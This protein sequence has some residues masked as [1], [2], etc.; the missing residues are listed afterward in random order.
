MVLYYCDT[1]STRL[2]QTQLDDGAFAQITP[3]TLRCM[4]C[5][6]AAA[7][8]AAAPVAASARSTVVIK[9]SKSDRS[10]SRMTPAQAPQHA[11]VRAEAPSKFPLIPVLGGVVLMLAVLVGFLLTRKPNTTAASANE[12]PATAAIQVPKNSDPTPP[13]LQQN[14]KPADAADPKSTGAK[15]LATTTP[16]TPRT[17]P[18]DVN[19]VK[20]GTDTVAPEKTVPAVPD[21]APVPGEWTW[22][23]DSVPAGVEIK[24]SWSWVSSPV[25]SGKLAHTQGDYRNLGEMLQHYFEKGAGPNVEPRDVFFAYVFMDSKNPPLEIMLQ[26]QIAGNWDHRAFWGE[27]R[28][29]FGTPN[30]P[31]RE[32]MGPLPKAGEWVRLEVPVARVGVSQGALSGL[33]FVQWGGTVFWD[34]AGIVKASGEAGPTNML[35]ALT[36]SAT[37]AQG[38]N[39]LT[40]LA[41]PAAQTGLQKLFLKDFQGGGDFNN[42]AGGDVRPSKAI[43]GKPNEKQTL[44]GAF[45]LPA[46]NYGAAT[47]V[48]T[49]HRHG[50]QCLIIFQLNGKEIFNGRDPAPRP[51]AWDDVSFPVPF[52]VLKPGR[53]ELRIINAEAAEEPWYMIN[54]VEL[55]GAKTMNPKEEAASKA[56]ARSLEEEGILFSAMLASKLQTNLKEGR[57]ANRV[58]YAG[59]G[60]NPK[61]YDFKM[62]DKWSGKSAGKEVVVPAAGPGVL[63]ALLPSILETEKPEAVVI[64]G[65][66]APTRKLTQ[67]ERID[68]EDVARL[69]YKMGVVPIFAVPAPGGKEEAETVRLAMLRAISDNGIPSIQL[70]TPEISQGRVRQLLSLLDKHV[71]CRMGI[72]IDTEKKKNEVE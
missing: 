22:I 67:V 28:I 42:H 48:V 54:A 1:C 56:P 58:L 10:V 60:W 27:D 6:N 68:W 30:T 5:V 38:V 71:F 19:V 15:E 32:R 9:R 59:A 53:N 43:W 17:P 57:S 3:T 21:S 29:P 62:L 50:S 8:Q 24:G 65:D 14:S 70:K 55:K 52:G 66:A 46:G 25:F 33:A 18:S 35:T 12:S 13:V 16:A 61:D 40:G 63:L 44:T 31:S 47:L 2:T 45:E 36:G 23:E 41:A 11:P 20:P 34:K 49:S 69:C 26:F 51:R 7:P 37:S 72:D 4:K 39:P 64:F